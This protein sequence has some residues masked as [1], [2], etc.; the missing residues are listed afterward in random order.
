M[1]GLLWIVIEPMVF[2]VE[3]CSEYIGV[4]KYWVLLFFEVTYFEL[5]DSLVSLPQ[6]FDYIVIL[7]LGYLYVDL[8]VQS[9]VNYRIVV[10]P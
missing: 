5:I 6:N 1:I 2:V 8:L 4:V 7:V 10:E 9:T 3:L